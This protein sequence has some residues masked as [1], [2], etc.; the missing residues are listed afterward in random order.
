[1]YL[2]DMLV[3]LHFQLMD[4]SWHPVMLKAE[5]SSGIGKQQPT[6]EQYKYLSHLLS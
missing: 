4:N 6:I 2:L 1:M 3:V 5:Y